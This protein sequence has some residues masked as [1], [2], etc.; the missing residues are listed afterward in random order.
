MLRVCAT[1]Q[2]GSG[3]SRLNMSAWR[4]STHWQRTGEAEALEWINWSPHRNECKDQGVLETAIR[5]DA[6]RFGSGVQQTDLNKHGLWNA[7]DDGV[8]VDDT[9]SG[10]RMFVLPVA[11]LG[12]GCLVPRA[13]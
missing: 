8:E 10:V 7:E 1:K 13:G 11:M 12:M 9:R 4:P 2:S 3:L 5:A 6:N